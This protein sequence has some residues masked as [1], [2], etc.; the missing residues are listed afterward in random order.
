[1]AFAKGQ[2]Y[3]FLHFLFYLIPKFDPASTEDNITQQCV[4]HENSILIL[5]ETL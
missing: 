3:I 2:I 4:F 1:M 5:E